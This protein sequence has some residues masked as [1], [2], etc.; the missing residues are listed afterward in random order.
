MRCLW[1][2]MRNSK[3]GVA[4]KGCMKSGVLQFCDIR[5]LVIGSVRSTRSTVDHHRKV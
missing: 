2:A 4:G 5:K 3:A 1:L